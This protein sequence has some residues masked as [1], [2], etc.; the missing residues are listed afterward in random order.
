MKRW[1]RWREWLR[2]GV[3]LACDLTD[4]CMDGEMDKRMDGDIDEEMNK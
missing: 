3:A 4:G 2:V 1:L